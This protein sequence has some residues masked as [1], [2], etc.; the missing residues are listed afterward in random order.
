MSRTPGSLSRALVLGACRTAELSRE[1]AASS[2]CLHLAKQEKQIDRY[3]ALFINWLGCG[4]K[5]TSLQRCRKQKNFKFVN[6]S[7]VGSACS[8]QAT[9][10]LFWLPRPL[11]HKEKEDARSFV[12]LDYFVSW[13]FK[14]VQKYKSRFQL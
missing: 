3:V 14:Q 1:V 9:T 4:S 10:R 8:Q 5:G 13:W 7:S 6:P 2:G 11:R 12:F